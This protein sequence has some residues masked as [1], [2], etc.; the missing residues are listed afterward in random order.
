MKK[1]KIKYGKPIY[2]WLGTEYKIG[3]KNLQMSWSGAFPPIGNFIRCLESIK[4]NKRV[5]ILIEEEGPETA[6]EFIPSGNN[7][8]VKIERYSRKNGF[9]RFDFIISKKR[10]IQEFKTKTLNLYNNNYRELMLHPCYSF[11]IRL[12]KLKGL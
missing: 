4:K 2:G 9:E 11:W 12:N 10:F 5:Q 3:S 7:V 1:F 6:F 8:R